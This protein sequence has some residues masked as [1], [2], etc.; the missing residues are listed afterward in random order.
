MKNN[1]V[2]KKAKRPPFLWGVLFL[3]FILL[4]Y[5]ITGTGKTSLINCGLANKF[6]DSDWLP[7]TVRRRMDINESLK[8]ELLKVSFSPKPVS[9]GGESKRGGQ[10]IIK[11]LKNL[12]LD[13]FKPVYI[14]F[15]QFEELFIFG[16]EEERKEF[17]E[18]VDAINKSDI[19]CKMLFILRE[20]F[21]CENYDEGYYLKYRINLSIP[22]RTIP[23]DTP[24]LRLRK[25]QF[26]Y[27]GGQT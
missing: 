10:S 6:N 14:L 25:S 2:H 19:Q 1:K 17:I 7:V 24:N 9:P 8:E 18:L 22:L 16:N 23:N 26:Y 4:I 12:Y 11:L 20:E 3:S 5:G 15:D 13:H 27:N 21:S